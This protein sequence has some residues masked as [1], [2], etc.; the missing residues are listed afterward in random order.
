[1]KIS[2]SKEAALFIAQTKMGSCMPT[3]CV[4]NGGCAGTILVLK[5]LSKTKENTIVRIDGIDIAITKEAAQYADDLS[6]V[7]KTG[8]TQEV[9]VVN[10][11]A[12]F[13]C[14]CE[15]SFRR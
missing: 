9:F 12:K 4:E 2:L 6:I 13:R 14:K 1:M 15:K 5:L 8:L 7:L 3:I 10:N 11:A